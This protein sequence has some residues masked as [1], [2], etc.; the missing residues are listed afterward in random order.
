[1]NTF[2]RAVLTY[3]ECLLAFLRHLMNQLPRREVA[4][5]P[6]VVLPLISKVCDDINLPSIPDIYR[7]VF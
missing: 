5:G 1:M 6:F 4:E 7:I 2:S 3:L